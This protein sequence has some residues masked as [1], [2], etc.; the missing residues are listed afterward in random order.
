M[1]EISGRGIKPEDVP[2]WAIRGRWNVGHAVRGGIAPWY[3]LACGVHCQ[4][5]STQ[6]EMPA[7]ICPEC[8]E[9]LKVAKLGAD[10][11]PPQS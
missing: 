11:A 3:H 1:A 5:K 9:M 7:R 10:A 8:R 6:K 4:P 2:L